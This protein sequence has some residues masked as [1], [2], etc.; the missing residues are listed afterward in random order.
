MVCQKAQF[1]QYIIKKNIDT[2]DKYTTKLSTAHR[3]VNI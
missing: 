2:L 1:T 3:A